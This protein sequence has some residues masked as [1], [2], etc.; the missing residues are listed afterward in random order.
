VVS[1]LHTKEEKRKKKVFVVGPFSFFLSFFSFCRVPQNFFFLGGGRFL[2]F[3]GIQSQGDYISVHH[4]LDF[5][6][7]IKMKLKNLFR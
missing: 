1:T 4:L 7:R 2:G 3:G 6:R 5:S